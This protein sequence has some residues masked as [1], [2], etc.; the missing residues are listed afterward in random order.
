MRVTGPLGRNWAR[1]YA[2]DDL[3]PFKSQ[4]ENTVANADMIRE[5]LEVRDGIIDS[6]NLT[7]DE[8]TD[9]LHYLCCE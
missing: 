5:L 6:P 9:V 4:D 8:I 1:L 3:V 2:K 7:R